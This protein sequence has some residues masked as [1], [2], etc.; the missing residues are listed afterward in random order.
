MHMHAPTSLLPVGW[1]RE[2]GAQRKPWVAGDAKLLVRHGRQRLEALHG[3]RALLQSLEALRN[4]QRQ[5]DQDTI[6]ATLDLKVLEQHVG[7][8]VSED[9]VDDVL[10]P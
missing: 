9:F 10:L 2:E 1:R 7:L 8:E 3:G 6:G 4:V 5:V